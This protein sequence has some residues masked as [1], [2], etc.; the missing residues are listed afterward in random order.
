MAATHL[1]AT[2]ITDEFLDAIAQIESCGGRYLVGDGG[3]AH[4]S[5]QMHASAWHDVTEFRKRRGNPVWSFLRAHEDEVAR[6]YARDYLTIIEAQLRNALGRDPSAEMIYAAYN[7]G[8]TRFAGLGFRL[9]KAPRTTQTA[10][11]RLQP[12]LT[13]L[14]RSGNASLAMTK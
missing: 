1:R 13:E 7:M 14:N 2:V 6:L 8:F 11:I 10:C 12:L 5:W 9:A 4:G 3:R